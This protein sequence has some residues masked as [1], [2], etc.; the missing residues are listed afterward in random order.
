M[1]G[2]RRDTHLGR[3]SGSLEMDALSAAVRRDEAAMAP[4]SHHVNGGARSRRLHS[5][6]CCRVICSL[7]HSQDAQ[8]APRGGCSVDI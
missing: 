8:H 4:V 2:A 5:H 3:E 1:T 6:C 7:G